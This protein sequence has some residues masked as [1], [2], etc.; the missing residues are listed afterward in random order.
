M[1]E[2]GAA[3]APSENAKGRGQRGKSADLECF[4]EFKETGRK[5]T[6]RE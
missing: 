1:N 6:S 4:P 5:R 3:A 2:E